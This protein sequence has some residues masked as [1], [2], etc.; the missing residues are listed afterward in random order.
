[1]RILVLGGTVFLGRHVVEAAV[2]A[3]HD[4]ALFNRGRHNPE[5]FPDL[6]KLRGDREGDVDALRGAN[7]RRCDRHLRVHR[8]AGDEHPR[9]PRWPHRS[10]HLRLE[11]LGVRRFALERVS[12]DAPVQEL[13]E[14]PSGE[15]LNAA[16]YG[17]QKAEGE[18]RVTEAFGEQAF[19]VRPGMIVG[20][21]DP[22]D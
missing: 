1:V 10:L 12:K 15:E 11:H 6:E 3:G 9:R 14:I 4:V 22:I 21:E 18:R 8:C 19:V 16:C 7:L 20:P 13:P 17:A 2:A 5:L